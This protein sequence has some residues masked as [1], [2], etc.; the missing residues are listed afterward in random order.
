MRQLLQVFTRSSISYP[1]TTERS[2]RG[3]EVRRLGESLRPVRQYVL[4]TAVLLSSVSPVTWLVRRV[5]GAGAAGRCRVVMVSVLAVQ[6]MLVA[7]VLRRKPNPHGLGAIDLMTL[8]RGAASAVLLGLIASGVRDRR[9]PAGW[10][11][12]C[13]VVYGAI[14]CDWLDGPL[15]RLTRTSEAG[16]IFDLE[17]DSWLTLCAAFAAVAWGSL[18][19]FA[20][21]PPLLRY[22]LFLDTVRRMGYARA[23]S[24][25]PP[26]ARR[27]GI[28]QMALLL[29]ALAPFGGR[30]TRRA[31]RIATPIEIVVQMTALVV[32]YR[33]KV[34]E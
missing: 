17:A 19:P 4:V 5:H 20:V 30:L 22:P 24:N 25:D 6:Q 27:V 15:A 31:V 3:A 13:S 23:T 9:G 33:R 21:L 16:T 2:E 28:A 29:A 34:R 32:L 8:S 14:V 7:W 12:W 18:G 1:W 11:G 10:L 26:W